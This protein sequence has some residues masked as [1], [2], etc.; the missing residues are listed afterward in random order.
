MSSERITIAVDA[1]PLT[2]PVSGV[3]RMISRIIE[4]LHDEAF[5]FHLF[6][7][8]NWNRDFEG[9]IKQ[10]NVIWNQSHGILSAKAGLWY[11][12]TLPMILNRM[13]P[14]IYWG[15]QQTVPA[16]LSPRIPTVLTFHDFVSYRFPDTIRLAARIQ[17][18]MLQRRSIRIADCII[19][20]SRQT[21][22]EIQSF[23]GTDVERLRVGYPGVENGLH[24]RKNDRKGDRKGG[25]SLPISIQGPYILSVSTI[26]PRKNYGML[27]EAYLRYHRSEAETPYSLVLAGRRGWESRE[28]F[29]RL[30]QIQ[31]ETGSVFVLE[32]LRD[33]Q[34][35]ALYE[36]ASFFCLPSLYEGFGIP[37]LEALSHGKPAV[38]SDLACFHEIAGDKVRYLPAHDVDS[39]AMALKQ[40]V[41]KHRSGALKEVDFDTARWSWKKTAEIYRAAFKELAS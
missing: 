7:P 23:F 16:F 30:D 10:S 20:N 2:H 21:M 33:D 26:E 39:W 9:V 41:E 22:Q 11:N 8:A 4:Q 24:E 6:A 12:S 25:K 3:S 40:M 18:R 19:A 29:A 38:V 13:K 34:L 31:Q 1:R 5:E 27:L 36:D 15:T 35:S 17:Q 14:S 37:L 32:G 28:F